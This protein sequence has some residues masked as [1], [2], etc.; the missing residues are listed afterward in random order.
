MNTYG[1]VSWESSGFTKN[2]TNSKDLFLRLDD[3]NNEIRVITAP[4]QYMHHRVK[5]SENDT[6]GQKVYCSQAHGSCPLCDEGNKSKPRWLIGVIAR[7]DGKA[8]ILDMSYSVFSQIVKYAKNERWGSPDSYD[9]NIVVDRNG[10]PT[11]YYAVQPYPKSPLSAEDQLLKDNFDMDE[12]QRRVNPPQPEQVQTRLDRIYESTGK[13]KAVAEEAV[14]EDSDS[15]E[16]GD[17]EFQDFEA[18]S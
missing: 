13:A 16:D 1:E 18:V 11:G 14:S 2:K 6:T 3:G 15:V 8:K 7:K 12:L 5:V 4:H 9:M 17:D 10:G